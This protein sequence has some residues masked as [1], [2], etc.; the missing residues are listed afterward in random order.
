MDRMRLK[1]YPRDE[2]TLPCF[3][4]KQALIIGKYRR[5]SWLSDTPDVLYGISNLT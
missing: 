5:I 4:G 3:G 1:G 2:E